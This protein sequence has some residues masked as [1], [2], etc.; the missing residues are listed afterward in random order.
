[1][2]KDN[3]VKKA[4]QYQAIPDGLT[5]DEQKY[6]NEW[7]KTQVGPKA[8]RAEKLDKFENETSPEMRKKLEKAGTIKENDD[9]SWDKWIAKCK[10][11]AKDMADFDIAGAHASPNYE[12]LQQRDMYAPVYAPLP[13]F[14][15]NYG[16]QMQLGYSG[17]TSSSDLSVYAILLPLVLLIC[18]LCMAIACVSTIFCGAAGYVLSKRTAPRNERKVRDYEV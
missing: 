13:H 10:Q 14:G 2:T 8:E 7:T 3:K 15:Y 11:H 17:A 1:V 16:P 12:E 4:E 5:E 18:F 6:I 9:A